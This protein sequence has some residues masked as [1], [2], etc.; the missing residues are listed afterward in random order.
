M[1]EKTLFK[2]ETNENIFFCLFHANNQIYIYIYMQKYINLS[3]DDTQFAYNGQK[4]SVLFTFFPLM[5]YC[6]YYVFIACRTFV[7]NS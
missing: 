5:F 1:L 2:C 7:V 3:P 6:Y 4:V